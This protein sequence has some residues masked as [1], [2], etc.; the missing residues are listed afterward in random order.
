M[1]FE[2]MYLNC[3][4]ACL[5]FVVIVGLREAQQNIALNTLE[6]FFNGL[7]RCFR[8]SVTCQII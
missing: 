1:Y 7:N 5:C 3:L 8:N 4:G 6:S 2:K